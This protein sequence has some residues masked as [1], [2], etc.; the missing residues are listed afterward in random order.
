M[1]L[2]SPKKLSKCFYTLNKIHLGETGRLSN[3]YYLLVA[4]ASSFLIHLFFP[5][6]V[7]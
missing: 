6:T 2:S 7:S 5:N 4:Q 1:E 3:L